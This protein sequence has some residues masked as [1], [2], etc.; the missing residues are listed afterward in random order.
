MYADKVLA[1]L[2]C[3]FSSTYD[4]PAYTFFRGFAWDLIVNVILSCIYIVHCIAFFLCFTGDRILYVILFY[5]VALA[6]FFSPP[7][8]GWNIADT[9]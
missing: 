8:H 3:M 2:S 1:F 7:I 6:L 4:S 9:A 5:Y